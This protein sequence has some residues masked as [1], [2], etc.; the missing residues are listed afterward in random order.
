M[1]PFSIAHH[2]SYIIPTESRHPV[3]TVSIVRVSY[4]IYISMRHLCF[5]YFRWHRRMF[6]YGSVFELLIC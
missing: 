1:K 2:V 5:N 4:L 3:G 6:S